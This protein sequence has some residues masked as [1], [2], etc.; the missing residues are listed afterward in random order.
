[1]RLSIFKMI[2]NRKKEIII[3]SGLPRSGTSLMMQMLQ[4]GGLTLISD[5]VRSAD[6]HNPNGYFEYEKVKSLQSDNSWV[7]ISH[8]KCIKIL[9][10]LLK[11]IP[12]QFNYKILFMERNLDEVLESQDKIIRER[13]SIG[14]DKDKSLKKIFE[15]ELQNIEEWLDRQNNISLLK[16]QYKD[17]LENALQETIKIEDFL[18]LPLNK[19]HMTKVVDP[20]LY[21]NKLLT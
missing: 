18:D 10:H 12:M 9:F 5:N 3:V 6:Y 7:N 1:M 11:F 13:Y 8:G 2:E 4:A 21:R 17:V 14:S 20:A 19:H 15:K 16:V